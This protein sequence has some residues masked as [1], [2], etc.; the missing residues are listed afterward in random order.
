MQRSSR[1]WVLAVAGLAASVCITPSAAKQ[2]AQ[3]MAPFA[4]YLRIAGA[5]P[6]GSET[7]ATCHAEVAKNF[8]HAYH[9]QQGVQCEECHGNGSLHVDGGCTASLCISMAS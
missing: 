1:V 4:K 2:A 9:A 3:E 8:Q 5:K 7:C 6:V